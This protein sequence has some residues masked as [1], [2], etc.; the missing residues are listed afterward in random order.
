MHHNDLLTI[1]AFARLS[2]LSVK[3][4]R[5]YADLGLLEPA[6]VD[7]GT[8]YRYYLPGQARDALTIGLL[9]SL[10]VPLAAIGR[11]LAG[12]EGVLDEVERELQAELE[13][14][15][16]T[17]ATL[18]RVMADGLPYT[19]VRLVREKPL[20]VRLAR[21]VAAGPD[22]IGRATSLAIAR[23]MPVGP[24]A[25]LIGLFP[26]DL[27]EAFEVTAAVVIDGG[28]GDEVLPG[29]TLAAAT[30]VGPY[31]QINLTAHTLLTWCAD[32][33]HQP[34]GPIREVY[35]SDPATT[36]PDQLVTHLMILLEEGS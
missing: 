7:A 24:A 27:S 13:R 34:A 10:D 4:L 16:R 19:Q 9:R 2:R 17:L 30:H 36:A 11:V 33:G 5:H 31:D 22:D 6:H 26:L 1:G 35:V 14:R 12:A 21:E 8:G 32:H 23:L 25:Q 18:R 29:G 20:R 3:Q 28:A 15:S